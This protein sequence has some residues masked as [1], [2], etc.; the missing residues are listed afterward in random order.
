[1]H[2]NRKLIHWPNEHELILVPEVQLYKPWCYDQGSNESGNVWKSVSV[3][4]NVMEQP[5]S[6][7]NK[8]ST[9]DKL[10]L[11]IKKFK[12]NY[13]GEKEEKEED[14]GSDKSLRD[15]AIQDSYKI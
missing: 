14:V 4:V 13:I 7:M 3:A 15:I 11:L 9:R 5:L 8:H 12:R 6:R 10:Y 2:A 1:M